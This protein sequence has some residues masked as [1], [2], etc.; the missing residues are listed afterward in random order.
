MKKQMIENLLINALEGGSN[1][2]YF[3]PDISMVKRN[4]TEFT[5]T[6][7][8]ILSVYRG[9][10]IPVSDTETGNAL[11]FLSTEGIIKA[12][13]LMHDHHPRH[14]ADVLKE[15]DDATTA[16]VFFQLSVMGEIEFA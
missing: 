14:Y 4:G 3:L 6:E 11:G 8:I 1:Y 10:K 16:D 9:A 5:L 2:W 7:D 12:V 15:E 13:K